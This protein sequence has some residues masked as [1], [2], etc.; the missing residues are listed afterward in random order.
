MTAF[1]LPR[2][3][4][5]RATLTTLCVATLAAALGGCAPLLLGGMAAG[6]V[7]VATDRRTS[8]TQL[9]DQGI[10]LRAQSRGAA[11][12]HARVRAKREAS[13]QLCFAAEPDASPSRRKP[14]RRSC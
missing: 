13:S 12:R 1:C 7:L 3:A 2:V 8:G 14:R 10:E 9:E 6:G 11:A 5:K 4:L